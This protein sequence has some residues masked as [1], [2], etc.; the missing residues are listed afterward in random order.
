M[1]QQGPGARVPRKEDRRFVTGR[2]RY[3]GDLIG[4][5]ALRAVFL[6]SP[7]AHAALGAVETEAAQRLPGV[8]AVLT[9]RDMAAD[10]LAPMPLQWEIANADGSALFKPPMPALAGDVLRFV[11]QP[12]AMA[13]ATGEAA[14]RDAAELVE[15]AFDERPAAATLAA[16]MRPDAPAVWPQNPTRGGDGRAAPGNLSLHWTLGDGAAAAAAFA[17]ARHVVELELTNQRLAAMP[18]EPRLA[19]ASYDGAEDRMLLT[20]ANQCPHELQRLLCQVFGVAETGLDVVA[21]DIGG[22]FGMKA[23][24]YPEEVALLWAARRLG[25]KIAWVGER[26]EAFLA[27]S[28]GRDH[29][30]TARLALDGDGRFLALAVEIAANMGAYLSQHAPAVPTVYCAYSLP[31]PYRFATVFA[32]V[33]CFFSHSAPIDA[34]RGAGRSEAVYV[35]ERLIDKAARQLGMDAALLR[36]RNLVAPNDLPFTTATGGVL[37]SGDAERLLQ[38]ALARADAA[39]FAARRRRARQGGRLRGLGIAMY[40]AACGGCA[41]GS[42]MAIGSSGGSWESARLQVH[43]SGAATLFVGSHNHGQGHETAF[44][45]LVAG[46]TGIA[47][48]RIQVVFGDTRRGPRGLGSFASRSAVVCG[49]AVALACQRVV[50]R[51][52]GI[53]AHLL[54]ATADQVEFQDGVFTLAGSNRH[55]S[56]DRVALAA[57]TA[58]GFGQDG[59]EPGLDETGFYDPQ[60]FTWPCGAHVAEVEIDP[61]T[62]AARL[63]GY[64]AADDIGAEINPMIV[65]GQLHGGIAQG[66]GQALM[67]AIHYDPASGQL[68]TGSFMDYAMPRAQALCAFETLRVASP[69]STNPLGA[70]GVGEVGTFAAPAAIANACADALAQAGCHRFDMPASPLALWR[71]LRDADGGAA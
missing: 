20:T 21:P 49:P 34:Y 8:V 9:G 44:A 42:A 17:T 62:G 47:L 48:E 58:A 15:A 22:G 63:L 4:A 40:A 51:A 66:A 24:A 27:D 19:I 59:R 54:D 31:G 61:E 53:A 67:E 30:A 68:V 10:G 65:D 60:D 46:R 33:R 26:S 11:G 70:K 41:S 1:A 64:V 55:A 23:Y 18:I 71:A 45:Q 39:G 7:H 16:A 3:V 25:R 50:A 38:R 69:C 43:P 13:I 35:T 28:G 5:D 36:R 52:R 32:R 37:E 29:I 57:Y 14:A 2:G 56:F 12:Y 6:R